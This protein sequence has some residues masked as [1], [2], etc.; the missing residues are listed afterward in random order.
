MLVGVSHRLTR[1]TKVYIDREGETSAL[2]MWNVGGVVV[3]GSCG[4]H[5]MAV[6]R[7]FRRVVWCWMLQASQS[8]FFSWGLG[9]DC[10]L[11]FRWTFYSCIWVESGPKTLKGKLANWVK[12][13][14]EKDLLNCKYK[15]KF[16]SDGCPEPTCAT[17]CFIHFGFGQCLDNIRLLMFY[18]CLW[19]S[20]E[21]ISKSEGISVYNMLL[22]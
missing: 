11:N 3:L 13:I 17:T 18:F 7:S 14:K 6:V 15:V 16:Q 2:K 21:C 10:F 9:A 20:L 4:F 1:S 8:L 12:K 19:V 5:Q 22:S